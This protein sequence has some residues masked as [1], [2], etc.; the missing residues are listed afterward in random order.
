MLMLTYK[1]YYKIAPPYVCELINKKRKPYECSLD[2]HQLIMP[3]IF[4]TRF[5]NVHSFMLLPANGT[6]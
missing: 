5:L 1:S 3:S 4:L 2:H 6:N